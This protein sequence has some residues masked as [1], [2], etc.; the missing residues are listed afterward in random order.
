[1]LLK[2]KNNTDLSVLPDIFAEFPGIEAVFLFGSTAGGR[3]HQESDLD[4]AVLGGG[5]DRSAFRLDLLTALARRGFCN[6]DLVLLDT[7]DIVMKFEA[8][9][10]NRLIYRSKDFERGAFYSKV[11]RQ[12]LDFLPYLDIQRKAYKRR[13]LHGK[14]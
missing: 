11:I 12:Y 1:M 13:I 4:L 5:A 8:L 10:P 7:E 3:S 14:T 9:S 6:V 2:Y